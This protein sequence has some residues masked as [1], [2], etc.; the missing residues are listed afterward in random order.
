MDGPPRLASGESAATHRCALALRRL[1][2]ASPPPAKLS[3]STICPLAAPP[4]ALLQVKME[5]WQN[6]REMRGL[7][8][9][10]E[11]YLNSDSFLYLYSRIYILCFGSR[12][13]LSSSRQRRTAGFLYPAPCSP[14][15]PTP[16]TAR[17][18]THSPTSPIIPN[19]SN[20]LQPMLPS[21]Q[22]FPVRRIASGLACPC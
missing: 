13:H 10:L 6:R 5:W 12:G 8:E 17:P 4:G 2:A 19:L 1:L 14:H 20:R 22:S 18:R 3:P 9:K 15:P 11:A 21:H 7:G 16:Q